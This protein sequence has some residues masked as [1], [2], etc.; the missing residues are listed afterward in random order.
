MVNGNH[1]ITTQ[2]Q[3]REYF[4]PPLAFEPWFPGTEIQCATNELVFCQTRKNAFRRVVQNKVVLMIKKLIK[5][6]VSFEFSAMLR[7]APNWGH[8]KYWGHNK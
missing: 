7:M 4:S 2:K 6:L 8:K 1:E 3:Q 5:I